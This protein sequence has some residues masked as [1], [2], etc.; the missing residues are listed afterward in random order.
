MNMVRDIFVT[1]TK[2][3][4]KFRKDTRNE[5]MMAWLLDTEG[6]IEGFQAGKGDQSAHRPGICVVQTERADGCSM[7]PIRRLASRAACG[8]LDGSIYQPLLAHTGKYDTEALAALSAYLRFKAPDVVRWF[9]QNSDVKRFESF[10]T[11]EQRPGDV[12]DPHPVRALWPERVPEATAAF[13]RVR[14]A[15]ISRSASA[16]RR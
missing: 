5:A 2:K 6:G 1:H 7:R 10:L 8:M 16:N 14:V 9:E 13:G 11:A 12:T 3:Q 4:H 15:L